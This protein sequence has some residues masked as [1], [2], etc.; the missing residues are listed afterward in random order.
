MARRILAFSLCLASLAFAAE[1]KPITLEVLAAREAPPKLAEPV[2]SPDGGRFIYTEAGRLWL[3]DLASRTRKELASMGSFRNAT[4]KSPAPEQ[5]GFENRRVREEPVQWAPNGRE[6]LVSTGDIFLFRLETGGWTQLTATPERER[7]PKLSPDGH[8]VAFRRA[9]DLYVLDIASRKVTRLTTDGSATLLNA[10]LDWVYP[11]EL[12]LGTAYWWSPDSKS[13]AYLQFDVSQEPLYPQVDLTGRLPILEPERY[14]RAGDPNAEVRLGIVP[15]A[16]GPTRWM[17]LGETR[18]TLRA[19]FDW[20]PD[21]EGIAVVRMNRIQNQLDL[22]L[23]DARTGKS[24]IL[25]HESDPYWINLRGGPRFIRGGKEFLWE[26]ER[27][28]FN[29]LYRYSI[30]G[31]LLGQLNRGNWEVSDV[32]GIDEAAGQVYYVSTEAGPLERQL[33]RV[34]IE[35]GPSERISKATGTHSISMAPSCAFYLDDFSSFTSPTRRTLH[36]GDGSEWAVFAEPDQA[37]LDQYVILPSEIL[38]VKA[39]DGTPLNARLIKPAGF[40]PGKKFPV[41]AYVYGGPSAPQQVQNR[42]YQPFAL[43]QV[44]AQRGYVV[45]ML[46]NRGTQGRGHAFEIPVFHRLGVTELEDQRTGVR[47]LL[48]LGF[49]DPAKVGVYGWSYG[50]FM[51]LR[52]LLNTP[53]VF[54]CGVAG[55]PVTDWRNYDSIYTERYMGLPE[56]NPEGYKTTSNVEAAAKL[57]GKLLLVHNLE[58]DN[59][60][61]QNSVQ[62]IAAL[63]RAGKQFELMVYT[64]KSH[65]LKRGRNHYNDLL[66][67][68]FDRCLR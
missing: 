14:P 4:V 29:H 43:E 2:W 57:K 64:D 63:E 53:D 35:G 37:T 10:E 59:V 39:G 54:A 58:D 8:L 40:D 26:S 46:D 27:D 22:L 60:L 21:S 20:L 33:Y 51:T 30:D 18:D 6:L 55:A 15:A 24:R 23:A 65:A 31:A 1:K 32:A 28:G 49:A 12:D 9:H 52:A 11:E 66:V 16:G 19:R 42:W 7:D 3:Y 17:D 45:W 61:F 62:M 56:A 67:S 50:G 36:R 38:Q 48:S 25:L 5:F 44:L 34:S 47:H 13:I 41:I 68:F